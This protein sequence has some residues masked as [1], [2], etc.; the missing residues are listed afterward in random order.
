[1]IKTENIKGNVFLEQRTFY[2]YASEEDR[3]KGKYIYCSSNEEEFEKLK[4]DIRNG[5]PLTSK[6]FRF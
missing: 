5:N 4:E 2:I 6:G 1:M 3:K